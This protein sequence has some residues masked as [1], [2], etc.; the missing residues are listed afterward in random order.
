[1]HANESRSVPL[2]DPSCVDPM[3]FYKWRT[4]CPIHLL[5]KGA[6]GNTR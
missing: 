4:P 1:M 2:D 5:E 6:A 3:A